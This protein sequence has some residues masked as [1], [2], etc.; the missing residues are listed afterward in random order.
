MSASEF[1][2]EFEQFLSVDG[3][4]TTA[5]DLVDAGYVLAE[6]AELVRA[7]L[8]NHDAV[9]VEDDEDPHCK[10]GKWLEPNYYE[11][12]DHMY[13]VLDDAGLVRGF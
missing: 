9:Y 12:P 4:F 3:Y 5:E 1:W 13:V 2:D 11:W 8:V 7:V 6:D 10:C